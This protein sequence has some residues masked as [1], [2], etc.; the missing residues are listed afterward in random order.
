MIEV[1]KFTQFQNTC[2]VLLILKLE[3]NNDYGLHRILGVKLFANQKA[4][5]IMYY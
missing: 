1:I 4:H 5:T 3:G 2:S